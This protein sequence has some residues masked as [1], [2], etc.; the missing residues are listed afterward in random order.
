M[1]AVALPVVVGIDYSEMSR[2]VATTAFEYAR[3]LQA[4][5]VVA[6]AWQAGPAA[7]IS[8]GAAVI[9][10]EKVRVDNERWLHEFVAT[11][12]EKFTD[13]HLTVKSVEGSPARHLQHLS[14]KAQ[15]VVVGS[16]KH[17]KIA[18]A[19]LGSVSQNMLH[20]SECSVLL[21]H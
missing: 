2:H 15:L 20:H 17:S 6:H 7:G 16:H 5:L 4:P 8:Y 9:D 13:V 11:L 1:I 12:R 18:G 14:A 21:V 10:W 19:V 3:A